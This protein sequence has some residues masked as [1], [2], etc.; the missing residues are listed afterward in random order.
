MLTREEALK[1]WP[2]ISKVYTKTNP[3]H[4][5]NWQ[6]VRVEGKQKGISC[7]F[8][9]RNGYINLNVKASPEWRDFWRCSI[10]FRH[11]WI[12]PE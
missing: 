3:F 6:L 4:D 10:R 8:M 11:C 5:P 12:P 7:G 1:I 9:R 2:V